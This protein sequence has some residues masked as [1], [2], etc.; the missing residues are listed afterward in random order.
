MFVARRVVLHFPVKIVDKPV[1]SQLVK[2]YNLT[3]NILRASI[4]PEEGGL[5]VSE[6]SGEEQDYRKGIEYLSNLGIKVQ[7]LSQD[8]IR[9]EERCTHCGVCIGIC[10]T[11]AFI[12]EQSTRYVNFDNSKCV[13]C[14]LC[15]KICPVKAMKVQF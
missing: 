8:I 12:L 1:I 13:A 10:P 6:L 5:M 3:F 4:T 11:E 9:D 7:P 2:D 15:T 14:E